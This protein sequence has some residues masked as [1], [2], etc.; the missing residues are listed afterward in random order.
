MNFF[1]PSKC[2]PLPNSQLPLQPFVVWIFITLCLL[3]ALVGAASI[4]HVSL[5]FDGACL[6]VGLGTALAKGARLQLA[7]DSDRPVA[8]KPLAHIDHA[9]FAFC[10]ALLELLALGGEGVFEGRAQTVAGRVPLNHYAVAV[11]EAKSQGGA[12]NWVR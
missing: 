7:L 12:C 11:L 2:A 6:L 4:E 1:F 8:A 9:F 5:L 10:I 3:D